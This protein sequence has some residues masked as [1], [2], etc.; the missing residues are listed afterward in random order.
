MRIKKKNISVIIINFNNAKYIRKCLSSVKNQS[1]KDTEIIFVD[2]QSIDN[3]IK[4][5][6]KFKNMDLLIN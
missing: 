1:Y 2:D 4:T 5:A 3:S 6:K